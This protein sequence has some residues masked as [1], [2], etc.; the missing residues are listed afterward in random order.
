M[1]HVSSDTPRLN[2]AA[3]G[4]TTAD[5]MIG[6]AGWAADAFQSASLNDVRKIAR[7]V[8]QAAHDK[9]DFHADWAV[10]ETGYGVRE[11][12][13][14]KNEFSAFPLLEYYGDLDLVTPKILP[15][16]KVVEIPRPAGVIFGL[17]PVTNPISTLNYKTILAILSR[18]A[19]V[20]SPHPGAR[21][22]SLDAVRNLARAA[23]KAGAPAGLIQCVERP[24]VPLVEHMMASSKISVIM[25]TGGGAMVRA[26]YSSGNPALGVGPGNG[27][28]W[29]DDSAKL[30]E[31]AR[32]IVESKSYDNSVLCTNESV[33]LAPRSNFSNLI[34]AM[35]T[36]GAHICND[37]ETAKLRDWLFPD[38]KFNLAA[39]GKSAIWI[40]EKVGIRVA[41]SAK[42]LVPLLESPDADEVFL[43]EK[44]CPVLA[45]GQ[46]GD[47]SGGLSL[48]RQIARRGAG[49][50]AAFHGTDEARILKFSTEMPVYRVVVNAPLSQGG[51]GLATHLP[52]TF[53]IGTGYKGR[54]SVGENVGPQHLV[55]WTRI[56]YNSDASVPFGKFD[57]AQME[58]SAPKSGLHAIAPPP[59]PSAEA[60]TD[61]PDRDMLR[62]LILEEL[63]SLTGGRT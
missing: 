48:A 42:I 27:V 12:K 37:D 23:E 14:Q 7:A 16:Q 43:R 18:N 46:V 35:R 60:Q 24:S 5:M 4:H 1:S 34:R 55:H 6:R 10:R 25:A 52:P 20:F 63:Q 50:S 56:A 31:A 19:I 57:P 8:A 22:C 30:D 33:L 21:E 59:P 61:A 28:A 40:A 41:R 51:A 26:A 53:M 2:F 3:P 47:F 17:I 45:M 9:A 29:V 36:A 32:R 49:H 54:S 58:Q 38:D 11:H 62:R 15:D 39:I 13:K 44:L